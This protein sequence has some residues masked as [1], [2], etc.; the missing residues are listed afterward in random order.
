MNQGFGNEA[1]SGHDHR[2]LQEAARYLV[3]IDAAGAAVARLFVADRRQIAEFD[4]STEEVA[5][6]T[7]GQS[8]IHGASGPE[9]DHALA[10][11]TAAERAA[12]EV[13]VL[14]I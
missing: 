7:I 9:W 11:H 6:M 2:P 3:L 5:S 8:A 13:Y 14:S 4:A 10:G 1:P 12:A